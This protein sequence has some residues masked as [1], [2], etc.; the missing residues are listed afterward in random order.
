MCVC[1]VNLG[2]DVRERTSEATILYDQGWCDGFSQAYEGTP[3]PYIG[4]QD[5]ESNSRTRQQLTA[6]V[7]TVLEVVTDNVAGSKLLGNIDQ[8]CP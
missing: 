6:T 2:T 4:M 1:G 5:N 7:C 3:H 8:G